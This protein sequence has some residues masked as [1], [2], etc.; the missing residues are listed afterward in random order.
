MIEVTNEKVASAR[1]KLKEARHV[2]RVTPTV[3]IAERLEFQ[4]GVHVF[5]K[6]SPTRG[7]RRFGIK[8]KLSPRFIGL[9]EILDRV[10]EVSYR[11]A[12]P[13]SYLMSCAGVEDRR[14]GVLASGGRLGCDV[15]VRTNQLLVSIFQ[16][17]LRDASSLRHALKEHKR[18]EI[19]RCAGGELDEVTSGTNKQYG[20]LKSYNIIGNSAR[21]QSLALVF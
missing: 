11:L 5:L 15:V 8:G 9:F 10:G 18:H 17:I 3:C 21:W 6:V 14:V 2:Q 1:E 19:Y 7:V 20:P 16:S 12:L 4:L 13:P